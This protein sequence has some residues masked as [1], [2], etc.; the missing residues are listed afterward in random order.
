MKPYFRKDPVLALQFTSMPCPR[1]KE[2]PQQ[3]SR[4]GKI[5]FRIKPHNHQRHSEGSNKS[6]CTPG[7]PTETE[8]DL[9][10]SV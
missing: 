1:A 8:A 2:K 3:D 5:A 4:R 10:L 6:L 9:V 7:D